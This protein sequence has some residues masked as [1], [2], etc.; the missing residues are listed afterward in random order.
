MRTIITLVALTGAI[1]LSGC[2]TSQEEIARQKQYQADVYKAKSIRYRCSHKEI[3]S[4]V[5]SIIAEKFQIVKESESRGYIESD[6]KTNDDWSN[7]LAGSHSREKVTADVLGDSIY[8]VTFRCP[9]Q[10]KP[11]DGNWEDKDDD[12]QLADKFYSS[13]YD[14]LKVYGVE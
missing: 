12:E 9:C 4:A 1:F 14:R 6:W 5:Y 3:W 11:K 10:Y 13:L 8:R 7:S 2:A